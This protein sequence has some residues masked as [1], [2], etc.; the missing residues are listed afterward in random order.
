MNVDDFFQRP[1]P[2]DAHHLVIH[3]RRYEDIEE[4][5]AENDTL[6]QKNTQLEQDIYIWTHTAI[7]LQQAYDDIRY[8]K[9]LLVR[10]GI[11]F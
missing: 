8:L 10:N 2:D 3:V 6:R 9:K 4:L 1:I 11:K 7:E 5:I